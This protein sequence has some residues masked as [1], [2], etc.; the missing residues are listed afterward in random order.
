M[1]WLT[2]AQEYSTQHFHL[3]R[4]ESGALDDLNTSDLRNWTRR[5]LIVD[6]IWRETRT[7]HPRIRTLPNQSFA[8]PRLVPGGRWLLVGYPQGRLCYYDLDSESL[9]CV[10][11]IQ[12][13][14]DVKGSYQDINGLDT[15]M[16]QDAPTLEFKIA[17][18][19][20]SEKRKP[21]F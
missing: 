14:K 12:P 21:D 13:S 2:L 9:K 15:D 18:C 8:V 16:D 10:D 5:R 3:P 1:I 20:T 7:V 4:P 17:M 19:G 11:L 6:R